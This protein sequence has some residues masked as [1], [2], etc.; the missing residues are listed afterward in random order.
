MNRV[1]ESPTVVLVGSHNQ[2]RTESRADVLHILRRVLLNHLRNGAT[3]LTVQIGIDL[4]KEI[5]WSRVAVL[6]SKDEG[7]G[8]ERLLTTAQLLGVL[9]LVVLAVERHADTDTSVILDRAPLVP[10]TLLVRALVITSAVLVNLALDDQS[11][12][13]GW[14]KFLKDLSKRPRDLLECP[15]DSLIFSCV[16]NLDEL[17]NGSLRSVEFLATLDETLT[18]L[19]KVVVLLDGLLVDVA[20]LLK[21]LMNLVKTFENLERSVLCA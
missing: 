21:C 6:D 19:G 10:G 12:T 18:L 20:E 1:K 2:L 11:S 3:V 5:E 8:A 16:K 4:V 13:T 7:K 14:N 15:L 17:L 9:L